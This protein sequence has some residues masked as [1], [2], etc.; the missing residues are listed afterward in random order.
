MYP[1]PV[2]TNNKENKMIKSIKNLQNKIGISASHLITDYR[3]LI[4]AAA[5]LPLAGCMGVYEGGFECPA[6]T[7]VGCKSISDVNEMVNE[8]TLPKTLA[9]THH[10]FTDEP[11]KCPTCGYSFPSIHGKPEIWINPLYL[12]SQKEQIQGVDPK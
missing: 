4:T 12:K 9:Q 5:A 1:Q 10:E 6:G 8:G 11:S 3:L 7:G 2:I